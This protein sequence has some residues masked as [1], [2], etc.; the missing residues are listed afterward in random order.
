MIKNPRALITLIRNRLN[1][2]Y[3]KNI[4]WFQEKN[5][6]LI[7]SGNLFHLKKAPNS[8]DS[9]ISSVCNGILFKGA[10]LVA[11]PGFVERVYSF[12]EVKD[13]TDFVWNDST[14]YV[15]EIKGEEVY[16]WWDVDINKWGFSS[17]T[18]PNSTYKKRLVE[19][20]YNI[21]S[22]DPSY[23]YVFKIT[24]KGKTYLDRIYYTKKLEEIAWNE[25]YRYSIKFKVLHPNL[26]KF[27]GLDKLE[28]SD[29]PII[30][31]DSRSNRIKIVD[32]I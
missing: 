6:V 25:V 11:W 32:E 14:Y 31:R 21:M 28:R 10:K 16:M 4:E 27:E 7:R 23:T 29:L 30:A 17:P 5:V 9:E 18:K 24:E 3:E 1:D 2:N 13:I 20:V 15:E 8:E 22:G 26:Y 12:D 19:N